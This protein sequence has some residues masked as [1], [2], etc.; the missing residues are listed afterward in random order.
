MKLS[1]RTRYGIRAVLE[2]AQ[3]FGQ[4]PLQLKTIA[5]QEDIS[6]KYLEQLMTLLKI[7]G[8]VGSIRGAKG[9]YV[10]SRPPNQITLGDC[11][12]ALEGPVV[13][14]KCV[15]DED[16]CPKTQSCVTR[17]IWIE[18]QNSVMEAMQSKTLQDLIDKARS[19]CD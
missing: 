5:E 19:N 3:N 7:G 9:G 15:D 13:T 1:T 8:L 18:I 10:L 4:G 17:Q 16:Y 6:V 2:L 11:F 14:V 12:S